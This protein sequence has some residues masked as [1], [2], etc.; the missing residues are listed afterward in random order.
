MK[1]AFKERKRKDRKESTRTSDC[2]DIS[3]TSLGPSG[4]S[5]SHLRILMPCTWDSTH[6]GRATRGVS[7][8]THDCLL[9]I[10]SLHGSNWES[11]YLDSIFIFTCTDIHEMSGHLEV[12]PAKNYEYFW[13]PCKHKQAGN[14]SVDLPSHIPLRCI[15]IPGWS[16]LT[17]SWWQE[18]AHE[19][20]DR[21]KT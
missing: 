15:I 16:D 4:L 9:C 8:D 7:C 21:I 17:R 20:P 10:S 14:G 3:L 2:T 12:R 19:S 18:K 13:S 1:H 11:A 5:S 6:I